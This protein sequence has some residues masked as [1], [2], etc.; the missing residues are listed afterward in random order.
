LLA[1]AVALAVRTIHR[2][3]SHTV[4][5]LFAS[6]SAH[7]WA[8][9]PLYAV[10]EPLDHFRYPPLFAVVITPLALL[11]P[12]LGGIL[13]SWMSLMVY[14]VGLRRFARDVLPVAWSQG[15]ESAFLLL[16]LAGALAGLWNA[17]S[18]ALMVGL[19]LLGSSA[20]VRQRWWA[21][22]ALLAAPV[23]LKLTP[24]PLVLLLCALWPRQLGWRVACLT[25]LG[26]LVPFLSRPPAMVCEQYRGWFA[27]LVEF[28]GGRWPGFRD[29]WTVW[30][31]LR[32]VA[33][34]GAGLPNLCQRIDS[35]CYPVL[36]LLAGLA[37]LSGSLWLLRRT[38]SVRVL[39][40]GTLALGSGWLMLLGPAVEPPTY[41]FLAPLLAWAFLDRAVWTNGRPLIAASTVLVLVLGWSALTRPLW[42]MIPWLALALPL[43][44]TLFLAWAAGYCRQQ[45][46]AGRNLAF[47][48]SE[49]GFAQ[50]DG[51]SLTS[52]LADTRSP[53]RS[54]LHRHLSSA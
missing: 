15:R 6:A 25:A 43:G 29:G 27:H 21:A 26:M 18:N 46:I 53:P 47:L 41:V 17:Q 12:I 31:V 19:L 13:W 30:V 20:V 1:L 45:A 11:G 42:D 9:L 54:P 14:F 24:L 35:V 37:V 48:C 49:M 50:A 3:E 10:Y 4:F 32:H 52:S 39:V 16:A 34:G 22:A 8:D 44:T 23:A 7:W 36:Q 28:S 5:P 51:K 40:T 38:S 2:P 33:G